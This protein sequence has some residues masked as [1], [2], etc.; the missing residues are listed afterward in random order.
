MKRLEILRLVFVVM[1]GFVVACTTPP[2]DDAGRLEQLEQEL[3]PCT[4]NCDCPK[5]SVCGQIS[6][7]SGTYCT[8]DFGPFP[9]CRGDCD[10]LIAQTCMNGFCCQHFTGGACVTYYGAFGSYQCDG[11][12]Q[13][14]GV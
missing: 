1:V 8:A 2:P 7:L 3:T 11:T 13:P 6:G 12:C 14:N 10:C 5:P 4:T 9:E